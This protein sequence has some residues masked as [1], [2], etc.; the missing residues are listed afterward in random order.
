MAKAKTKKVVSQTPTKQ[1]QVEPNVRWKGNELFRH[2]LYKLEVATHLRNAGYQTGVTIIQ[3]VEHCHF[4]HSHSEK[5][6]KNIRC[7]PTAGHCH[8]IS[9][10][11]LPDGTLTATCGPPITKV[12]KP[13]KRNG[14]YK[15]F[16][17][18][19]KYEE[20]YSDS[21]DGQPGYI[22]D[23]HRH[24]ITYKRSE[25]LIVGRAN[26]ETQSKVAEMIK[27]Q[28]GQVPSASFGD[29]GQSTPAPGFDIKSG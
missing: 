17:A 19:I 6:T 27:Q 29:N 24:E 11:V 9:T 22:V 26:A 20:Q 4:F 15:T 18:Q 2:D 7:A 10:E 25:E 21:D 13:L 1:T 3:S 12:K 28:G 23:N 16:W 14:K 8:E 5:G